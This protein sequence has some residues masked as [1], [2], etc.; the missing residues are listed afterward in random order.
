MERYNSNLEARKIVLSEDDKHMVSGIAEKKLRAQATYTALP[1]RIKDL[2]K[3]NVL[4]V[5]TTDNIKRTTEN[6]ADIIIGNI[7]DA[8][9][10]VIKD[11]ADGSAY[12]E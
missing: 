11:V 1:S 5:A 9:S 3:S 2:I 7:P 6:K 8:I 12:R 4:I 10:L